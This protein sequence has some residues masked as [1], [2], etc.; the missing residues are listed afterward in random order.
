M[1]NTTFTTSIAREIKDNQLNLISGVEKFDCNALLPTRA[2]NS[3]LFDGLGISDGQTDSIRNQ[4]IDLSS[5]KHKDS[6]SLF[7]F[8]DPIFEHRIPQ[9]IFKLDGRS[10]KHTDC[11]CT[12]VTESSKGKQLTI[13]SQNVLTD[14]DD[15]AHTDFT[16]NISNTSRYVK[17]E[18]DKRAIK[19][20]DDAKE[21]LKTDLENTLADR[22]NTFMQLNQE[23]LPDGKF[24]YV[25]NGSATKRYF[26][27]IFGWLY[28]KRTRVIDRLFNCEVDATNNLLPKYRSRS[29]ELELVA[30]LLYLLNISTTVIGD[31]INLIF[32][33]TISG[34]SKSNIYRFVK[35]YFKNFS[36]EKNID[37]EYTALYCDASYFGVSDNA[38]KKA[39]I[40]AVIGLTE[41][42]NP[43]HEIVGIKKVDAED[44]ESWKSLF[45][46]LIKCGLK[47]P[48]IIVGDGGK[49][50]WKATEEIFSSSTKQQLCWVHKMRNV[51]V[52]IKPEQMEIAIC[53]MRDIF[54]SSSKEKAEKAM[55]RFENYFSHNKEVINTLKDNSE[56]LFTFLD[57][58]FDEKLRKKI[59]TTNMIESFFSVCKKRTYS[60]K[61]MLGISNLICMLNMY[62]MGYG[63]KGGAQ[64]GITRFFKNI[65][66][67]IRN[68]EEKN[69]EN[70][71]I[72]VKNEKTNNELSNYNFS[73]I[74][75]G[76][77]ETNNKDSNIDSARKVFC[78]FIEGE[79]IIDENIV[80]INNEATNID[81]ENFNLGKNIVSNSEENDFAGILN[82]VENIDSNSNIYHTR[83]NDESMVTKS[84]DFELNFDTNILVKS[85]ECQETLNKKETVNGRNE[86]KKCNSDNNNLINNLEKNF[87]T[88]IN[89]TDLYSIRNFI[90]K[91][92]F[93]HSIK[94]II[95]KVVND[96]EISYLLKK[97][98]EIYLNKI[99]NLVIEKMRVRIFTLPSPILPF[100]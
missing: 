64:G 45:G 92:F 75:G 3:Q 62:G 32:N 76:N 38:G 26:T 19:I 17:N 56:K 44:T 93:S 52:H 39:C 84:D 87:E 60:T 14:Q 31:V 46:E 42:D 13:L 22:V 86:N 59:Y 30:V 27:E 72:I 24:R 96:N 79:T 88:K 68:P 80:N 99:S 90:L 66:T 97:L 85:T 2:L 8:N 78:N 43:T 11:P 51:L 5:V 16:F 82:F 63:K 20:N 23:L 100:L 53:M 33:D 40:L 6:L 89:G 71:Q 37:K 1:K 77:S 7:E 48:K 34:F 91:D 47:P 67:E 69:L 9:E 98:Y 41:E 50:L 61:G 94:V 95:Q 12:L 35:Y 36:I 10:I 57:H 83:Q 29:G 74:I 54:Q 4:V 18:I 15:S 25:R 28:I 81:L 21:R 65:F 58:S 49:G 70:E 55:E 73:N